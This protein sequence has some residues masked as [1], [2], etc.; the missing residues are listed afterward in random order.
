M[1][2]KQ[3]GRKEIKPFNL[4]FSWTKNGAQTDQGVSK[5]ERLLKGTVSMKNSV[6]TPRAVNKTGEKKPWKKK[7]V[8]F[9]FI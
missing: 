4:G 5:S 6:K 3:E 7:K 1:S 2:Q 8:K 9:T